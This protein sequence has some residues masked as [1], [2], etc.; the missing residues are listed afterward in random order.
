MRTLYQNL[1]GSPRWIK[2]CEEAKR[3]WL[4]NQSEIKTDKWLNAVKFRAEDL[5]R[6]LEGLLS[7]GDESRI[8]QIGP[9]PNGEINFFPFGMR[10]AIDPLRDFFLEYFSDIIDTRVE[11]KQGKGEQLPY[12]DEFFDFVFSINVLDHVNDVDQVL[13][14]MRRVLKGDGICYVAVHILPWLG[15]FYRKIR[16]DKSHPYAFS[17]RG[18]ERRITVKGFRILKTRH[19]IKNSND[20][21]VRD[22]PHMEAQLR[23]WTWSNRNDN[24][25]KSISL[26]NRLKRAM[27]RKRYT[28]FFVG[29]T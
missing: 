18:L 25:L 4:N 29:K 19:D 6:S 10:Y 2:A 27:L 14:E 17:L 13:E 22:Y 12:P 28:R 8:L 20:A 1:N 16:P 23:E 21:I 11:F 3:G 26:K 7:L 24:E 9:G 15:R 5:V